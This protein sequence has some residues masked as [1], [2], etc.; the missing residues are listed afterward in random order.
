MRGANN[1]NDADL[2]WLDEGNNNIDIEYN[3]GKLGEA[4]NNM[5]ANLE[6][7]ELGETNKNAQCK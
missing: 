4:N 7:S 2:N 1:K 6:A 3:A 5:D